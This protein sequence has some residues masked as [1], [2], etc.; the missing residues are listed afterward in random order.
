MRNVLRYGGAAAA[1]LVAVAC[2]G[3][4]GFVASQSSSAPGAPGAMNYVGTY[5]ITYTGVTGNCDAGSLPTSF[6]VTATAQG[7][8]TDGNAVTLLAGGLLGGNVSLQ[9]GPF[10]NTSP[11]ATAD[12]PNFPTAYVVNSTGEFVIN[13]LVGHATLDGSMAVFEMQGNINAKGAAD[14][15]V[16]TTFC[17]VSGTSVIGSPS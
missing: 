7:T 6:R 12:Q 3:G 2:S 14:V 10:A 15:Q 4:S 13:V 17:S 5:T 1:F 9:P 11:A 8:N 16:Q